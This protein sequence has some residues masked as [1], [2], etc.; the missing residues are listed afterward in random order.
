MM[1]MMKNIKTIENNTLRPYCR[2][3]QE[4]F[5]RIGSHML[6][7]SKATAGGDDFGGFD[8]DVIDEATGTSSGF[9][10]F[11]N[12]G[13]VAGRGTAFGDAWE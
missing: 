2:P 11:D 9:G 13:H 1:K 7:A 10:A 6:C 12:D 8:D 5:E 4:V 3:Q